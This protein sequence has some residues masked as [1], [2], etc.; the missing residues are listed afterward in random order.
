MNNEEEYYTP[1]IA[2]HM[3]AIRDGKVEPVVFERTDSKYDKERIYFRFEDGTRQ[4]CTSVNARNVLFKDYKSA[5]IELAIRQGRHCP[6]N[7]ASCFLL[8]NATLDEYFSGEHRTSDFY[9]GRVCLE[10]PEF[11]SNIN[12]A[13]RF[14]SYGG[15]C[16][17][18]DKYIEAYPHL[19]IVGVNTFPSSKK[20]FK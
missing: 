6:C 18:F 3:F 1:Y 2:R 15:A 13:M 9:D 14:V 4:F 10:V 11:T 19:A 8:W 20:L 5:S 17:F 7:L 12:K 16:R